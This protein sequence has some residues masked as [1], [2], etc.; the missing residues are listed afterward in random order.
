[1]RTET[2]NTTNNEEAAVVQAR[3]FGWKELLERISYRG[4]VKNTPY[5]MFLTLLC[6]VYITN[7]NRAIAL[8]RGINEKTKELKELR[9]SYLDLQSRLMHERSEANIKPKAAGFGLK[10]LELPAFELKVPV[11]GQPQQNK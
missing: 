2:A 6:I 9:W 11:N 7:T 3:P 4:I 8:N 1:M 10:P 5:L